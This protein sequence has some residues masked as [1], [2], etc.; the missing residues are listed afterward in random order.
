M[1][2]AV[3]SDIHGNLPALEAVLEALKPY[4]AI[5]QLG[6]IVGYG[7]QPNEVVARLAQENAAGV[8][9]NHDSAAIGVL[10]TDT[11]NDDARAARRMD[12]RP[13]EPIDARMAGRPP[14]ARRSTS[15]SPSSTAARATRPGS[16]SSP[17]ASRERT[18][19]RSTPSTVWSATP[20]SR[21]S[22]ASATDAW[23]PPSRRGRHLP[24]GERARD[25]QPRQRRPAARRRSTR[26]RHAPRHRRRHARMASRRI[27]D[28]PCPEVDGRARPAAA[29]GAPAAVRL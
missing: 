11:F 18:C 10:D 15:P 6:D 8:R 2:I 12:R 9:G 23:R 25:R 14:A 21:S 24:L 19:R 5:W 20:T 16:T 27:S 4:D 7:P 13:I 29:P 1:R 17:R 26:E 3:L 22:I 28:R